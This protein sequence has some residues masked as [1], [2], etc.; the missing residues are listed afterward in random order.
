MNNAVILTNLQVLERYKNQNTKEAILARE[1]INQGYEIAV[2]ECD[3]FSRLNKN[4][5]FLNDIS[6]E[7]LKKKYP[8]SKINIRYIIDTSLID[9]NKIVVAFEKS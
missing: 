6:M 3:F 9:S 5:P 4:P 7:A 8:N 1:Y 2:I